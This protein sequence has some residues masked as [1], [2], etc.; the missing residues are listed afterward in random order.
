MA[1]PPEFLEKLGLSPGARL[2][3]TVDNDDPASF[4]IPHYT[5][6][7]LAWPIVDQE[8]EIYNTSTGVFTLPSDGVYCFSLNLTLALSA[9][10]AFGSLQI[11]KNAVPLL[12]LGNLQTNVDNSAGS[13]AGS[14][15]FAGNSGDEITLAAFISCSPDGATLWPDYVSFLNKIAL[16]KL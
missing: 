7:V 11:D 12:Q 9:G 6:T 4:D 13:C 2:L 3:C 16:Y 8:A 1:F 15:I 5:G 10:Y 14:F